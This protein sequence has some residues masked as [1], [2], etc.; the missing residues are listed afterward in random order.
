[1]IFISSYCGY[2][3]SRNHR[4]SNTPYTWSGVSKSNSCSN[5]S[6]IRTTTCHFNCNSI[7]RHKSIYTWCKSS[8]ALLNCTICTISSKRSFE[9]RNCHRIWSNSCICI[10]FCLVC[11]CNCIW[12][13][14]CSS[15]SHSR[16]WSSVTV[17]NCCSFVPDCSSICS[18]TSFSTSCNF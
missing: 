14:I 3:S 10:Y 5:R 8:S 1:M 13:S 17:L 18:I 4:S 12:S 7:S 9:S 15:S 16:P 2:G 11:K 6:S